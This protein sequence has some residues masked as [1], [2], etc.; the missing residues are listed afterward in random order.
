MLHSFLILPSVCLEYYLACESIGSS[1][2]TN[3][4][5]CLFMCIQVKNNVY[6][7]TLSLKYN[8][9]APSVLNVPQ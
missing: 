4:P 7:Q 8:I 5:S 9:T 3:L 2:G 1:M 6:M